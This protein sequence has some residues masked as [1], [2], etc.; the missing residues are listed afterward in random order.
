MATVGSEVA[1]AMRRQQVECW[2]M[3]HLC[4]LHYSVSGGTCDEGRLPGHVPVCG[5]H[6]GTRQGTRGHGRS[7]Y[8][9]K[10]AA[11]AEICGCL[12]SDRGLRASRLL[13]PAGY[14][15]EMSV[16]V[17]EM[18]RRL[19]E[20]QFWDSGNC[21]LRLHSPVELQVTGEISSSTGPWCGHFL[22]LSL[23]LELCV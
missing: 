20:D 8:P 23:A 14:E 11:P 13:G 18:G 19:R 6:P 17:P 4:S 10:P 21:G 2:T 9:T 7:R 15:R 12:Y 5:S 16:N 22:Y 1:P 3:G